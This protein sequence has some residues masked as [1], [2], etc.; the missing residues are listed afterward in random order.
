M[1]IQDWV[2]HVE[3]ANVLNVLS[4]LSTMVPMKNGWICLNVRQVRVRLP[5]SNT[6]Y[7]IG[8]NERME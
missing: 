8:I 2:Q 1:K 6:K 3:V 5:A 4:T 7:T